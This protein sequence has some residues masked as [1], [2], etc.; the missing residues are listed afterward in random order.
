MRKWHRWLSVFFGIVMIYVA[1]TGLLHYL[2][3]WWPAA[4]PTAQDLAAMTPP[5]GWQCP[6]GWRCRPPSPDGGLGSML[7]LFHHLHSGEE[8]G[9][10]GEIIVMLSG[11]ALVFFSFSGLWMYLQMW[12]NRKDRSQKPGWFWE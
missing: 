5:A 8:L 3:I 1:V 9:L 4:P 7:G 6:E 2:A 11:L 12:K 10:G